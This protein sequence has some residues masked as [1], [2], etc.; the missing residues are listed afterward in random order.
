MAGGLEG[1]GTQPGLRRLPG[2][3]GPGES[4]SLGSSPAGDAR[5]CPPV[6]TVKASVAIPAACALPLKGAVTIPV[7][8]LSPWLQN[9]V[10]RLKD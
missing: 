5:E 4:A 2:D 9:Q 3:L 6:V 10:G 1:G 7:P 8:E